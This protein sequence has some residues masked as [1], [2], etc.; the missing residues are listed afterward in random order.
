MYTPPPPPQPVA[1]IFQRVEPPGTLEQIGASFQADGYD[2]KLPQESESSTFQQPIEPEKSEPSDS[3]KI[4][5][6]SENIGDIAGSV[7]DAYEKK[8][9]IDEKVGTGNTSEATSAGSSDPP[10]PS[11]ETAKEQEPASE[12]STTPKQAEASTPSEGNGESGG[13]TP[14][15][16]GGYDY[17]SGIG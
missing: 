7:A 14:S 15:A 12:K 2:I 13:S 3:K 8:G 5:A 11:K 16:N 9:E 4:S 1:P 6:L 10:E 17:Y